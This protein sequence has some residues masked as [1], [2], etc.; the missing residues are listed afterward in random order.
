MS[1]ETICYC[2]ICDKPICDIIDKD[3]LRV[4]HGTHFK[5]KRE[6]FGRWERVDICGYCL[7]IIARESAAKRRE[8]ENDDGE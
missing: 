4:Y 8:D 3:K 6:I 1:L 7:S 5:L 2:D